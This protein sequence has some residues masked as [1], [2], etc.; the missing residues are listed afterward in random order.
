MV[1]NIRVEPHRSRLAQARDTADQL[2]KQAQERGED[3]VRA[4]K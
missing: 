3:I 1:T 4:D 2:D